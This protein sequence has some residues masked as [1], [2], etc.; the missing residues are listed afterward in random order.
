MKNGINLKNNPSLMILGLR[1]CGLYSI[2]ISKNTQLTSIDLM[3]NSSISKL[4]VS[5]NKL[6]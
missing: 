2:D 5:N 1:G 6:I 3:N 4:D